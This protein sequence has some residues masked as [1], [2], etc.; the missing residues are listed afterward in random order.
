[1]HKSA[2]NSAV[3]P[4]TCIFCKKVRYKPGTK[5]REK[6]PSVEEFRADDTVRQSASLQLSAIAVD[7]SATA[8]DISGICAKDLKSSEAKYH[9]SCYK[10]FVHIIYETDETASNSTGTTAK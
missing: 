10:T 7:M 8:G 9:S 2:T 5:T 1:M 6:L 4:Q 3:L